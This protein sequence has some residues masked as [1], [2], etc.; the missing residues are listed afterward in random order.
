MLRMIKHPL[1]D[2]R[3]G[4]RRTPEPLLGRPEDSS[5]KAEA[6]SGRQRAA[7]PTDDLGETRRKKWEAFFTRR[8]YDAGWSRRHRQRMMMQH[9][10][11]RNNPRV[12]AWVGGKAVESSGHR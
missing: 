8:L 1:L 6:G 5:S 12:C 3:G 10:P 7:S 9:R 11:R 4:H 2:L